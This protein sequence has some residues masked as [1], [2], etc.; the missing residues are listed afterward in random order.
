MFVSQQL[1]C[2][3]SLDCLAVVGVALGGVDARLCRLF[4]R[5]VL[6]RKHVFGDI[7][8]HSVGDADASLLYVWSCARGN[9][10][11]AMLS[12]GGSKV[13][14]CG[15]GVARCVRPEDVRARDGS[16]A[17]R[18][19]RKPCAARPRLSPPGIRLL[20]S[21]LFR[22]S[23]KNGPWEALLASLGGVRNNVLRPVSSHSP[24][25]TLPRCLN[26]LSIRV[27]S[28]ESGA[29]INWPNSKSRRFFWGLELPRSRQT[30]VQNGASNLA[31]GLTVAIWRCEK[32]GSE[33]GRGRGT[34]KDAK[35]AKVEGRTNH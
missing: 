6:S 30:F 20:T 21:G 7:I 16:R 33:E 14:A 32:R 15:H 17:A 4:C 27:Y 31:R 12:R 19:G 8:P 28:T 22:P 24:R 3:R 1:R 26:M 10:V 9:C 13:E 2:A 35:S 5:G 11:A 18:V 34:A 29:R 23:I 25:R